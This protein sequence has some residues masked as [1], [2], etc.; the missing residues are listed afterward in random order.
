MMLIT[1]ILATTHD[2][3]DLARHG[4]GLLL[5]DNSKQSIYAV[6]SFPICSVVSNRL[7]VIFLVSAG[8]ISHYQ[9]LNLHT[10]PTS[11]GARCTN[12]LDRENW[13]CIGSA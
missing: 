12:P 2:V 10:T 8:A 7:V 1:E 4:R 13:N 11:T 5:F 6:Y 3:I 9:P